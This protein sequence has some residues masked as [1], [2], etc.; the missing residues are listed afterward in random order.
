MAYT[1]NTLA[2]GDTITAA[3]LNNIETGITEAAQSG[4]GGWDA[5]VCCYHEDNSATNYVFTIVSG[6]FADLLDLI[7]NDKRAPAILFRFYHETGPSI[8]S[9]TAV[10]VYWIAPAESI[11][12][13]ARVPY[14]LSNSNQSWGINFSWNIDDTISEY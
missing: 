4:G 3:K 8:A 9:T 10:A 2:T 12:F 7:Q 5:E 14:S 11:V 13:T 6:T 1:P